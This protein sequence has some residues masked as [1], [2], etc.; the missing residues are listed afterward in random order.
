[1]LQNKFYNM[2]NKSIWRYFSR[3]VNYS[4]IDKV[5]LKRK[6]K[7]QHE[8]NWRQWAAEAST[9]ALWEA[10]ECKGVYQASR[11]GQPLDPSRCVLSEKRLETPG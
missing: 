9:G 5:H 4:N 6:N 8:S 7:N 3:N 10:G 1:M 2:I 11:W